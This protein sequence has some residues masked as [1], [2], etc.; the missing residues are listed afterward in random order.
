MFY[1]YWIVSW[2]IVNKILGWLGSGGK[3]YFPDSNDTN[4][5]KII[6]FVQITVISAISAFLILIFI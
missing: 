3:W 5:Q 4:L 1:V 6:N 2:I